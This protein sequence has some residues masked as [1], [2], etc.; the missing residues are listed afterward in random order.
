MKA[1]STQK[2]AL[3]RLMYPEYKHYIVSVKCVSK[4]EY[5]FKSALCC[6]PPVK[7]VPYHVSPS[8]PLVDTTVQWA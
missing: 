7:E 6:L 3:V 2:I 5:T 4:Q 1:W 8:L